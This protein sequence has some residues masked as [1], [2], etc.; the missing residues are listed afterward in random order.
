MLLLQPCA[1]VRL[2][3]SSSSTSARFG[4]QMWSVRLLQRVDASARRHLLAEAWVGVQVGV[5]VLVPV[6]RAGAVERRGELRGGV[7]GGVVGAGSRVR[8]GGGRRRDG[9]PVEP[10]AVVLQR[11]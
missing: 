4:P 5:P 9:A 8:D 6:H 7:G 1:P 11:R 2:R 10:L 3:G